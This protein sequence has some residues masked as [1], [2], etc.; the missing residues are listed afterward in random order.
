MKLFHRILIAPAVA[1]AALVAGGGLALTSLHRIGDGFEQLQQRELH[2]VAALGQQQQRLAAASTTMYRTVVVLESLDTDGLKKAKGEMGATIDEVRRE[3]QGLQPLLTPESAERIKQADTALASVPR[4]AI[5]A[6]DAALENPGTA[7]SM[8]ANASRSMK[9]A[10]D[11]L[12]AVAANADASAAASAAEVRGIVRWLGWLLPALGLAAALIAVAVS[13]WVARGVV[14]RLSEALD[15]SRALARGDLDITVP[16]AGGD[17][18]GQLLATMRETV[19]RLATSMR[20]ILDASEGI[21]GAS[22]EI[23]AGSG[24]L[25]TR[26][27]HAASNLAQ[28]ATSVSQLNT[29]VASSAEAARTA[30]QVAQGTS[31]TA[32]RGGQ[33]V[34]DVVQTMQ[35]IDTSSRRVFEIISVIDGIAFQTNI[36]ALNAAVEAARAGEQGRGFAVVAAEVRS[37][38]QRSA[39]A[40]REIKALIG[41]SVARVASGT[42]LVDEA[43]RTMNEILGSVDE[44]CRTIERV[45]AMNL[46][47]ASGLGE[48]QGAVGMLD[49]TTQ[50]NAALAEQS[51]AASEHLKGQAERLSAIVAQ[52][53]LPSAAP[54]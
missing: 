30:T 12:G 8:L 37:L 36:L 38:A 9:L 53:R 1:V 24:D 50:Q 41:E 45:S 6:F 17:E 46:E 43:G 21:R 29:T 28:T 16:S 23:A 35:Q 51:A 26:T 48:V 19:A 18:V 42:Q 27:E 15:I 33:V 32:R 5:E 25:S 49:A 54:T 4:F 52:F 20:D 31:A 47:Q 22:V 11:H 14:R 39:T 3:L 13:L 44:V 10:G 2:A 40:A 7:Q 34:A